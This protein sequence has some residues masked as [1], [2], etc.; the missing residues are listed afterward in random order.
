[1]NGCKRIRSDLKPNFRE[2][3][4][5]VKGEQSTVVELA[6]GMRAFIKT[7]R[8]LECMMSP[9]SKRRKTSSNIVL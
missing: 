1:M 2:V 4:N 3:E 5:G 9:L 7:A 6:A 8:L